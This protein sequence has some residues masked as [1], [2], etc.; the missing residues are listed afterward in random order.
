LKEVEEGGQVDEGDQA[1]SLYELQEPDD[2]EIDWITEEW[3]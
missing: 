1:E 2:N 3:W